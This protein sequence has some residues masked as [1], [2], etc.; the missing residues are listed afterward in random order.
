LRRLRD[1]AGLT[2]EELAERAGLS[3]K[4]VSDLERGKRRR[5]YPH[6]V[7]SL[8]DALGLSEDERGSLFAAVPKRGGVA[9]LAPPTAVPEPALP[10]PPTLLVGREREL[11]EVRDLLCRP[12]L[13]LLTL[14]GTGGVGKTHL[15]I[16][17][18][19]ESADLF[20]DGIL[21]VA[22]APL[23]D[24]ALVISTVARSLGLRG[25]GSG[26]RVCHALRR[27]AGR[28]RDRDPAGGRIL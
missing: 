26:Y 8:A 25:S 21:F 3:P 4:G 23:N 12:K 18:A 11:A 16:Q 1:A 15:A 9:D 5:P 24:P 28:R 2:Q 13:R 17:A 27:S 19:R 14:T 7:R 6:T 20:P 22:L 10:S